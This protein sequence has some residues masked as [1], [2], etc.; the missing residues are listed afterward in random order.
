[1]RGMAM[2]RGK[3]AGNREG[4][5]GHEWAGIRCGCTGTRDD[6]DYNLIWFVEASFE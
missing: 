4:E 2:D 1:M 3:S 6:K 5:E